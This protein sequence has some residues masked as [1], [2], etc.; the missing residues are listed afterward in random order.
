MLAAFLRIGSHEREFPAPIRRVWRGAGALPVRR[1]GASSRA[2]I[3]RHFDDLGADD[4]YLR[5]GYHPCARVIDD[6]VAR[7][8][9]ERVPVF[10]ACD[11]QG[12]LMG[13]LE[14]RPRG[15]DFEVGLSVLPVSQ[16]TGLGRR[17]L[18]RALRY[19]SRQG[20]ERVLFFCSASNQSMIELARQHGAHFD[21]KGSDA[22]GVIRCMARGGP[23][24]IG[25]DP[26][27]L[28]ST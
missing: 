22:I 17:L 14:L 24:I 23:E 18:S 7:L 3:R 15:A 11:A 5:F 6:Y 20:A 28:T 9:L 12:R 25:R 27:P 21:C 26:S 1:L 19:A 8:D 10:G 4:R 13:L 2:A 16:G